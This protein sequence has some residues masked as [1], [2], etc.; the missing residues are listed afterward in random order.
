[1]QA[2]INDGETILL[3]YALGEDKS[4]VWA[5][6]RDQLAS[7]EL[8]ASDR[9]RKLVGTLRSALTPPQLQKQESASEYQA[10]VRRMD[11]TYEATSKE[12]SRVLL[13]P[14]PLPSAKRILVVPDGSLQYIPF[15]ALPVPSS[16][17]QLMIDRY[18]IDTLPSASVLGPLRRTTAGKT[19]APG[20]LVVFADPVF[21]Q[22]DPRVAAR[23]SSR[24]RLAQERPH[25]LT[26]AIR[27][28]SGSQYIPR[29]PAS[30]DEAQAIAAIFSPARPAAVHVA[31]DF[32]ANRDYVVNGG[33]AQFRLIHF[34]T[35]GVVDARRPEMS[36]LILSLID[37]RGR[38]QDGYLRIGDIYKLALSA[39]LVVLSSC[40]SALGKDMESEGIIG[41]PRAFLYAGAKSVI[42]SL[43]KV[44]DQAS[45]KMMSGLYKRISRG[46]GPGTALRAAQLEMA[47]DQR[48]SKPYFWAAFAVQGDYR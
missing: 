26:R 46:E 11:R 31:L 34:A 40:E 43:W 48:W 18:E 23:P 2:E 45:A 8:P 10:R 14:V 1:V 33:L 30:R 39:D 7:Y 27:D 41:L 17:S 3:E 5:V 47:H 36:G 24:E 37:T 35:H 4:Y 28:T 12:L 32:D 25:S 42:A 6:G 38:K 20:A 9:I 22:D 44:D 15:A 16:E 21:E 19:S 13:G 29:L